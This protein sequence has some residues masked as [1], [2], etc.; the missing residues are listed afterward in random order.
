MLFSRRMLRE[1][2]SSLHLIMMQLTIWKDH[3]REYILLRRGILPRERVDPWKHEDQP[4]LGCKGLL[5]QERHIVEI[6]IESFFRGK[7][8]SWVRIVN[9][10]IKYVTKTS[11][12]IL[13]VSV[14]E[15][16]LGQ[17]VAKARPRPTPTL[18]LSLVCIPYNKRTWTDIEPGIFNQSF[19]FG[20]SKLMIRLLQ[21]DESV[22]REDDG[23]VR[24]DDLASTL[25]SEFDG[26][27]H[28]PVRAWAQKKRFQCLLW[29][30]NSSEHSLY[31]RAIQGHS[32][33]TLVDPALWDNVLL[34]EDFAEYIHH[35]ENAHDMH[36]IIQGGSISG[37][38][39]LKMD[40]QSVFFHGHESDVRQSRSGRS[41]IRSG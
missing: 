1:D 2:N 30:P 6:M 40:R 33:G 37:G 36:S 32:G 17:P 35:A 19:L 4:G 10:I 25:R 22:H 11:E 12:E 39:S 8:C 21:H 14:G 41:S 15:R 24:F 16:S 29:T 28:W 27:S 3:V 13:V 5:C 7:T 31:F 20:V 18:T 9:G 34:P 23:A 38:R 26:T